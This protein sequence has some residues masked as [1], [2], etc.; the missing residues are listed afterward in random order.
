MAANKTMS[1]QLMDAKCPADV[2]AVLSA[3]GL[4]DGT[5]LDWWT[6][7]GPVLW[8]ILSTILPV[9]LTPTPVPPAP[10]A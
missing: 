4:P 2:H 10:A 5:L 6:K 9:I 7:F 3:K 8:Q 1:K